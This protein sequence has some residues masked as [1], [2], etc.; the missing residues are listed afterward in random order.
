[1]SRPTVHGDDVA[2]GAG[3]VVFIAGIGAGIAGAPQ[4][5]YL[6]LMILPLL[7]VLAQAARLTPRGETP[8]A[9]T[10]PDLV[11]RSPET[12][13][14]LGEYRCPD[15][16]FSEAQSRATTPAV[17]GRSSRVDPRLN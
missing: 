9:S 8:P 14:V 4:G 17:T 11:A 2:L 7:M 13:L 10:S 16:R 15:F 6:F 1:M 12:R 5:A 3:G